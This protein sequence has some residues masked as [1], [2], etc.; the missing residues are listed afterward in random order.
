MSRR[1]LLWMA[2]VFGV[3]LL[4]ELPASWLVRASGL[5]IHGVSGTLW[6]G[7]A[8]QW[9]AVGPLQWTWQPWRLTATGTLG[10]QGQAWQVRA[11]GW[12]WRWR[13]QAQAAGAQ[14]TAQ[15]DYRL[16]G[17][18]QGML[19]AQG[20]GRQCEG[21]EG[22]LKVVDLAVSAP[23]ALALGQ[24]WIELDCRKGW[25]LLG[26]LAL[27]DQ[28]QVNLDADLMKRTAQIRFEMQPDAALI[29]LLR[30]AQWMEAQA[31]AGQRRVTW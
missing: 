29:P 19:R 14:A 21:S 3:T 30:G 10:Y 2:V 27:Q 5:A 11:D 20:S 25:H 26:Q 7:Q 6:Q 28:H 18:W 22:R 16:S 24:G 15:A 4:M 12:P 9:G 8:Q 1:G 13:L 31:T 23:W 17:Q